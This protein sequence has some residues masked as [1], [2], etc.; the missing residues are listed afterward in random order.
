MPLLESFQMYVETYNTYSTNHPQ[1]KQSTRVLNHRCVGFLD[2]TCVYT[3]MQYLHSH[4]YGGKKGR[5]LWARSKAIALAHALAAAK[6]SIH[7][8]IAIQYL[9]SFL[10]KSNDK[11]NTNKYV[12]V[13]E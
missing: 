12:N 7:P 10:I 2:S 4:V 13:V 5:V 8:F 1:L 9:M 3:H 6:C 11:C